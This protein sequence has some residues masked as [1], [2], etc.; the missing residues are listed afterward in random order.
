[1]TVSPDQTGEKDTDRRSDGQSIARAVAILR[2]LA[3]RPGASFGQLAAMTGMPRSTVQRLIGV[4]NH[5]GLVVKAFGQQG[6][7]LGMELARLGARVRIDVRALIRPFMEALHAKLGDNIDLTILD[8]DR[9][10]V[11][12][13]IA[14]HDQIR[15]ISY[16][17]MQHPVH[18][19]AN[20]KAHL[21][22]LPEDRALALIG[23]APRAFT[24][25]TQ[26]DP[27]AILAGISAARPGMLFTD[28]DEYGEGASAMAVPLSA[29]AGQ[30]LALSLA[31]PTPRFLRLQDRVGA[32][33][34]ALRADVVAAYGNSI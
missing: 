4:L 15:V 21:S 32:A 3:E 11:I 28:I 5:E 24:P 30:D 10:V 33:L 29:V 6:A 12:E 26:T 18:C 7:Y 27:A 8:G 14:S 2:A 34:L 16:V 9:V 19:T 22:M 20:G 1:M 13:Q 17:G 23:P 25:R 31:M